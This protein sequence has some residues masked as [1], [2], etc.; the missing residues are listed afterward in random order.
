MGVKLRTGSPLA[1]LER[2]PKA[3]VPLQG[4]FPVVLLNI[5]PW[6]SIEQ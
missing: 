6:Y 1:F 3:A 5:Y 2:L 4:V